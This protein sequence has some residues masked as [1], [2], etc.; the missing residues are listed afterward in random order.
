VP[1]APG[2]IPHLA[3]KTSWRLGGGIE[4]M[5]RQTGLG[6]PVTLRTAFR[7]IGNTDGRASV[8]VSTTVH[9][10][11]HNVMLGLAYEFSGPMPIAAKY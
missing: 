2:I 9:V 3:T 5:L 11:S 8:I 7:T 1:A 6:A 4:T 10:T